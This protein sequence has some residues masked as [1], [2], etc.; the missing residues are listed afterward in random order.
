MPVDYS[1]TPDDKI[2]DMVVKGNSQAYGELYNRYLDEIYRYIYYR[3]ANNHLEAEDITQEVFIRSWDVITKNKPM[4][5]RKRNFR[6]LVYRIA[7]NLTV[8]RWRTRKPELPLEE[9]NV[10]SQTDLASTPEQIILAKEESQNL[11]AAIRELKPQLQDV[12]ICR[13]VNGLSHAETAQRLGLNES[14]VRVL[15]Y[16][17]LKKIRVN[18]K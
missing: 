16:R 10:E 4:G 12:F 13:F 9:E 17:A 15:Q 18:I 8:D 11:A 1:K 2:I 6:A 3:V 5:K 7:H 14:H